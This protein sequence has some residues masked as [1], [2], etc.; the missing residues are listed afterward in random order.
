MGH[1]ELCRQRAVLF[2]SLEA[3]ENSPLGWGNPVSIQSRKTFK[4][5]FQYPDDTFGF[6][7]TSL[8]KLSAKKSEA[9]DPSLRISLLILQRGREL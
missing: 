2:W 8:Q 9:F 4:F 3:T 1:L 6:G 7:C 5:Q